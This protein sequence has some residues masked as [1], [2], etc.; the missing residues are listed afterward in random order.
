VQPT[1]SAPAGASIP[2]PEDPLQS[3]IQLS[4]DQIKHKIIM[5]ALADVWVRYQCDA[6][7]P[8][9]FI[10]RKDRVL[11]L[12]GESA[13]KVQ[14][15]NPNAITVNYNHGGN[16]VAKA[17]PELKEVARSATLTFPTSSLAEAQQTFGNDAPLPKT[18]DPAPEA[19][20]TP[21]PT[22]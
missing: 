3:G 2:S 5:K 9:K 16:R 14:F 7:P 21:S 1:P 17:S 13:V 19:P 12:R 18:P 4:K 15:S 11:V 22:P 6:R 10:L 8:M 20:T